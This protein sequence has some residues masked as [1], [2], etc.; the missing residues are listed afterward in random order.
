MYNIPFIETSSKDNINVK[1]AFMQ[2]VNN[3]LEVK[4][5]GEKQKEE[6]NV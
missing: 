2:L 1:Q 3:M 4:M 5:K 6:E